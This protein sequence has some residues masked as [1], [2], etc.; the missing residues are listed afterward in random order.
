MG[1]T[2]QAC[3][4]CVT[5]DTMCCERPISDLDIPNADRLNQNDANYLRKRKERQMRENA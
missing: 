5:P 2:S 4:S 1:N 3:I